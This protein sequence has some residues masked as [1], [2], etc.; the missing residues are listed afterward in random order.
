MKYSAI[1]AE[2]TKLQIS[3]PS[4]VN[5]KHMI[6]Q[7]TFFIWGK[8]TAKSKI[9]SDVPMVIAAYSSKFK[10][11][12]RVDTMFFK[13][14]GTHYGLTLPEGGYTL[15]IYADI[16]Q[17]QVFHPS[18]IVAKKKLVLNTINFPEKTVKNI[19]FKIAQNYKVDWAETILMPDIIEIERPL[20]YPAGTIRSLEDPIFD[21]K[22][23]TMG[24][25]DP[26]SFLEYV[27][28][29]FYALKEG[30]AHK[31]PVIFVHGIGGSSRSFK[32]IIE[33][34]DKDRYQ[35]WFFY[36]PSGGDLEQLGDFFYNI[37]LSGK[38]IPLGDMP[39]IVVAHSMGGLVVR[40]AFNKYQGKP[41]ENKVELFVSIASPFGG[42]PSAASGE[43]HG[44]I[45]L[46]SWKDLNPA[47]QFIKELYKKPLP[48]SVNHQLFYAY[49]NS[50]TLKLGENSDGVVPLSSQLYPEAQRQSHE[51]FGFNSSHVDILEDEK[52]ITH[53]LNKM[54][55]VKNIFPE[56]HIK[57]LK[58]GGFDIKLSDDY[59]PVTRH[60]ISYAG[61]YLVLLV[62]EI[63]LPINQEQNRY[64]QAVK[65]E[66]AATRDVEREFM[67]FMKE[68]PKLVEGVLKAHANK[69][70]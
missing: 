44:L 15:L 55:Q 11:N 37:F 51:Q 52:M 26:A 57:L 35:A 45:V 12:E 4:Q 43:K 47:S 58:N 17:D 31:N 19:D 20:Y 5:L 34:M 30:V 62:N 13:G 8:T 18:E 54:A 46:P 32:P 65:G 25:Y 1:Q 22:M 49:N 67:Q 33:H 27:Q 64:I 60:L 9:Y 16:N 68:Y 36:Y 70:L 48:K 23:A 10:D 69:A 7:D 50:S 24:M 42:H 66:I 40:E 3:E 29:M 2:Y 61:K 21:E 14:T 28:T 63:I 6:N 39:I 56:S 53:L 38:V 41:K 59:S